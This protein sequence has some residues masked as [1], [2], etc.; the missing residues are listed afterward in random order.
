[1]NK[2]GIIGTGMLVM[3]ISISPKA[4]E[5]NPKIQDYKMG[6][7]I[8]F[9]SRA[10]VVNNSASFKYFIKDQVAVET[11]LCFGT[12]FSIGLLV[13]KH[14]PFAGTSLNYFYGG[15]MYVGFSNP[16][17]AGLQGVIGLDY[18]IP[19]LPF[20]LSL[21]WKPELNFTKDFFFEPAALGLSARFTL[22]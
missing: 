13:E 11:L 4:Q 18:K 8:R 12:P 7:G 17:M 1:M 6:I 16:A 19:N 3:V 14:K 5:T 10:P 22:N 20:N 9:S 15:G 2:S 21:D